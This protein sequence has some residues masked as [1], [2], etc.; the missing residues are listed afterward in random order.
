MDNVKDQRQRT[1]RKST[2]ARRN[3]TRRQRWFMAI[4]LC[5]VAF[6][7]LLLVVGIFF[8]SNSGL[9]LSG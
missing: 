3:L 4:V 7:A 5:V 8:L 9:T 6:V 2:R 1:R